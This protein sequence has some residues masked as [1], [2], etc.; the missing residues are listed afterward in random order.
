MILSSEI[1]QQIAPDAEV[2]YNIYA[3]EEHMQRLP[4]GLHIVRCSAIVAAFFEQPEE[5]TW[6]SELDTKMAQRNVLT[7]YADQNARTRNFLVRGS[8]EVAHEYTGNVRS[9]PRLMELLRVAVETSDL[10]V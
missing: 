7:N 10:P 4:S 8:L 6:P 2:I 5:R 9:I 1:R 3:G